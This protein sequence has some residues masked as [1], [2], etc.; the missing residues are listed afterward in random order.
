MFTYNIGNSLIEAVNV[1]GSLFYGVVLGIFL[2]AFFIPRV[3]SGSLVFWAALLA[4]LIVIAVFLLSRYDVIDLAFLWLNPLGALLVVALSVLL[5]LIAK[6][7]RSKGGTT[8]S[9]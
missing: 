6:K 8:F 3:K 1:L 5:Q 9:Q 4:E 7:S 2:V